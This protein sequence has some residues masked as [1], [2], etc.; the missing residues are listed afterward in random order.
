MAERATR[1]W[2]RT[3][4]AGLETGSFGAWQYLAFTRSR[5]GWEAEDNEDALFAGQLGALGIFAVADG[6]GG[7]PG[8]AHAAAQT[9]EVLRRLQPQPA[10]IPLA[11]DLAR[12]IVDLNAR[13][14][15]RGKG[16]TTFTCV[17]LG[18][19]E[20]ASVHVGDSA[21]AI[22]SGRG[23]LKHRSVAHSPAG[24]AIEAGRLD[25]RDLLEAD[26]HHVV[27]NVLGTRPMSVEMTSLIRLRPRDTL[28]LGSD[29]LF[30]NLTSTKMAKLVCRGDLGRGG[31]RLLAALEEVMNS[32]QGKA[33]DHSF[34]LL[35]RLP[36]P[37]KR[38]ASPAP[39]A[40]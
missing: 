34:I 30:D 3:A 8:G 12:G 22:F 28:V 36:K 15:R 13:L 7:H 5:P 38:S 10:P 16:S 11:L 17:V 26:D 18:T 37:A 4:S 27:S 25:E 33:D 31:A 21:L 9:L 19:Q 39:S 32:P 29:G 1:I 6:V 14:V 23:R 20:A 35:R 2:S 40:A 24:Y